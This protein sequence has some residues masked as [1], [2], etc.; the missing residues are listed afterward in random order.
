[1]CLV[2]KAYNFRPFN[3]VLFSAMF[4]SDECE[5]QAH[6]SFHKYECLVNVLTSTLSTNLQMALRTFFIA[7]SMF[8]E[9]ID[10]LQIFLSDHQAKSCTVFDVDV[11]DEQRAKFL[12]INSLTANDEIN[13]KKSIFEKIFQ[14]SPKLHEL[15]SKYGDFIADFLKRQIQIATR[16]YHEIYCWPLKRGSSV[17]PDIRNVSEI[18]PLAY[19]RGTVSA[20]SAS[21]PFCSLINH[22]CAPNLTRAFVDDKIVLIVQRP[23]KKGEQLFDNYGYHFA[24]VS[25]DKRLTE[26]EKQYRFKCDCDACENNWPLMADLKIEDRICL[27]KAKKCCRELSLAPDLNRRK[28]ILKYKELCEIVEKNQKHFPSLETCSIMQS[29]SAYLEMSIKPTLQFV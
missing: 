18:N 6:Q 8:G 23:I 11:L 25:K 24:T 3:F 19:Q 17:D 2:L 20:G 26:L 5:S 22:H 15:W 16:N 27:N 14:I 10:H 21:Y 9:S 1:M 28:S 29:A 4:C 7:I 13:M 12:A